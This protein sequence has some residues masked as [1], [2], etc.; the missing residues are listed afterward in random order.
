MTKIKAFLKGRCPRC[1]C[2]SIFSGQMYS[3]KFQK[4]NETCSHCKLKFEVE[5]GYFYAAMYVSY[6]LNVLEGLAMEQNGK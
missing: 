2:G 5:P 6:A 3:L 4:M 1:H